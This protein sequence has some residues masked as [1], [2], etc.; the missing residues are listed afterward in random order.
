MRVAFN[1][2]AA[3]RGGAVTQLR[4]LLTSLH[5]LQP[6]WELIVYVGN[7]SVLPPVYGVDV[8]LIKI[9]GSLHRAWL[10][11]F[12]LEKQA[13]EDGAELLVN[14]LNSGA[15]KP[16]LPSVTWQRNALYFDREWLKHQTRRTRLD[17]WVRRTA[18]LLTCRASAAT[19]VPT[20]AM[21]HM[22]SDWRLGRTLPIHVVP[23][24]VDL[25]AFPFA[26]KAVSEPVRLGVMGHP[27][28]HRG[29]E[30]AVRVLHELLSRGVRAELILTVNK[31]GNTTF[32]D[33]VDAAADA[34]VMLGVEEAVK[35]GGEAPDPGSWYRTLDVLLV[36]S[37][38][39]SFGFPVIEAFACGTTVVTSGIPVLREVGDEAA[40][41]ATRRDPSGLAETV[42]SAVGESAPAR[43][44]RV[45]LG[46]T[47]AVALS[48]DRSAA[49]LVQVVQS[50]LN[51]RGAGSRIEGH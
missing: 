42:M 49:Q 28:S 15:L 36:P 21:L 27:A 30:M 8:R 29:L 11:W 7:L 51:A 24:G 41:H 44:A 3:A 31:T 43:A 18:A 17:A 38:C 39:E 14:L 34:A 6:D 20:E 9:N 40:L 4:P 50:T 48:W 25:G 47:L 5:S 33:M 1:A 22:V 23:H 19:V 12:G 16:S 45:R 32:Q 26:P 10:E 35:F 13:R 46:R 2:L 37:S